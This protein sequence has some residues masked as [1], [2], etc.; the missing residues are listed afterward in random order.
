MMVP[1]NIPEEKLQVLAGTL[2]CSIGSL[3]FNYLG[4]PLCI[5][6]PRPQEFM[7]MVNKCEKRL[8]YVSPFL[9]QAGRLQLV[10]AVFSALPTFFMCSIMLP[11]SIIKQIDKYRKHCLW[12]GSTINEKGSPKAAWG[13]ICIPKDQGGMGVIDLEK[14]NKALIMKNLHKFFNRQDLPWV[15]LIWE[16]HYSNNKL[17]NHTR[18]GSFWWRDVLK[19]L[20]EFKE[21]AKPQMNNGSTILFWLDPW[22]GSPLAQSC[23]ELFSFARNIQINAFKV[24]SLTDPTQLVQL[25][26]SEQAFRQFQFIQDLLQTRPTNDEPDKWTGGGNSDT[27]S[28][29]KVYRSLMGHID[30]H[31]V[32]KWIWKSRAQ[33]KHRVFFWL[34]FKDRLNTKNILRRKK[35][36]LNSYHCALCSFLAEENTQHLF[37]NCDFAR[38]C[39]DVIGVDIPL[40]GSFPHVIP[41]L[42][43]QI[44]SQFFMET[45]IMTCWAIWTAR[46]ELI[47]RGNGTSR[48][49]YIRIFFKELNLIRFRLKQGQQPQFD[50]WIH[51]LE[52]LAA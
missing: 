5:S 26:L 3:P 1:I 36:D 43:Y 39:W 35:M 51:Q 29:K 21:I 48:D 38:M 46:N 9:S 31:P 32:Y 8:A 45:I 6:R 16:K 13:M 12:R 18:K 34:L 24:L 52:L 40:M 41:T 15:N 33:P 44:N 10:N 11:K 22:N 4:L 7:P 42:K 50:S 37:L 14:Q 49:D 28:T 2:G 27:Y 17:P 30:I 19:L 25:P 23:P 47:F 20:P